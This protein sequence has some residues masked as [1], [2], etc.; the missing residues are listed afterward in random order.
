MGRFYTLP[1]MTS[2]NYKNKKQERMQ[3]YKSHNASSGLHRWLCHQVQD[4]SAGESG[5]TIHEYNGAC[6]IT[7]TSF[8]M[9]AEAVAYAIRWLASQYDTKIIHAIIL[10]FSETSW[11]MGGGG[12]GGG[13]RESERKRER[14]RERQTDRQ[15]DRL[16]DRHRHRQTD[17]QTDWDRYRQ[18]DRKRHRETERD[19]QTERER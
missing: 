14:E 5:Q 13:W 3:I 10:T 12:G 1:R 15:T 18:T 7:T 8:T 19:R 4:Q 6:R 9:K 17:R 16:T 11:G 2:L